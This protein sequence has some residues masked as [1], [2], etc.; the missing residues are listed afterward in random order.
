MS[1]QASG[2]RMAEAARRLA[3]QYHW[4]LLAETTWVNVALTINGDPGDALSARRACLTVYSQVLFQACQDPMRHE[5]AYRELYD[6]LWPQ[7]NYKTPELAN[8]VAQMAIEL[9]YL[10]FRGPTLTKCK[11]PKAFLYF[12]Q[13]KLRDALGR[14]KHKHDQEATLLHS[15]EGQTDDPYDRIIQLPDL[16]PTPEEQVINYET[17]EERAR[18]LATAVQRVALLVLNCLRQLWQHRRLHRQLKALMIT[19]MDRATDE[20]IATCLQTTRENVQVLRTRLDKLRGCL[21]QQILAD[22]RN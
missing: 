18:W 3:Q 4:H 11:E 6:Y 1:D 8:E 2:L 22:E 15:S 17:S 9:V 12:A 21:S 19:F 14:L 7:A 20:E 10:S 5:Q 16:A 13:S